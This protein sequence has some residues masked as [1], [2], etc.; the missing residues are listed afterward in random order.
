MFSLNPSTN[1]RIRFL[2]NSQIY[3]KKHIEDE[4][5]TRSEL[6]RCADEIASLDLSFQTIKDRIE[7]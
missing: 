7:G 3:Y 6:K 2:G 4:D 1:D 5:L